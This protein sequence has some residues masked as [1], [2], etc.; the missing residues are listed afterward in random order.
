MSF[1]V[2]KSNGLWL[3]ALWTVQNSPL[4]GSVLG[5]RYCCAKALAAFAHQAGSYL[6]VGVEYARCTWTLIRGVREG[7]DTVDRFTP[8]AAA[9]RFAVH[10]VY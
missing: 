9:D 5:H 3:F 7:I 2:S 10:L 6:V 1:N 4:F 8:V